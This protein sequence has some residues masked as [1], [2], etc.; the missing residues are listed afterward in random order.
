MRTFCRTAVTF[1]AHDEHD[2]AFM[3]IIMINDQYWK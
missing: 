2:E 3:L 1:D